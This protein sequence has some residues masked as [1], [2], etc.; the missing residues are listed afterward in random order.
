MFRAS[1]LDAV[2]GQDTLKVFDEIGRG[3]ALLACHERPYSE[4]D[5]YLVLELV[6]RAHEG[7]L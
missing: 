7:T 3:D 2:V 6:G 5:P 1:G 4:L